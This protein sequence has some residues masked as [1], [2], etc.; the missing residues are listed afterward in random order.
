MLKTVI[1]DQSGNPVFKKLHIKMILSITGILALFLAV[2]LFF[3]NLNIA[4]TNIQET[5][6]LLSRLIM[7]GGHRTEP[8]VLPDLPPYRRIQTAPGGMDLPPGERRF[9]PGIRPDDKE[10]RPVP[11]GIEPPG[12]F[13]RL[14]TPRDNFDLF[15]YFCLK[16]DGNGN[17]T[18]TVTDYHI[19]FDDKTLLP[20]RSNAFS[21]YK[22]GNDTGYYN[23][24]RWKIKPYQGGYLVA[25]VNM[26]GLLDIQRRLLYLSIGFYAVCLV[27]AVLLAFLLTNWA[28]K[29]VKTAFYEQKQFVADAG[30]ELKTPISVIGANVDVLLSDMPDNRWLSYIKTENERLGLLVKDLLYLAH[31]DSGRAPLRKTSFD[32]AE[33]MNSAVLPFESLIYEQGKT[34][35]IYTEEQ[36]PV[37]AD[38]TKL[39]EVVIV[40]VDNAIKNSDRDALI[41][42]SAYAA[43]KHYFI[44]VY[45]TGHGIAHAELEKVFLRFYRSDASRTRNTGG[46]GLGL[47]IAQSIV[48]AHNGTIKADSE[49]GRWA[50]FTVCLP[51]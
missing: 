8:P 38:E 9:I 51:V 48:L 29:P 36:M 41:K 6:E 11:R 15:D 32:L 5:G 20:L 12:K 31:S 17:R 42:V 10:S 25:C 43:G 49:F 44:K 16:L 19:R 33:M 45:N 24:I 22:K 28:I 14:F 27:V 40:L 30:H 23:G 21:A 37:V 26:Q 3:F 47:A 13:F 18:E 35:E 39:K 50:E 4:K 7:N 34:L 46:S 2:L 1:Q